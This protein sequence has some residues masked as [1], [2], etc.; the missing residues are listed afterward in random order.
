MSLHELPPLK[1]EVRKSELPGDSGRGVFATEDITKGEMLC[2]YDGD[3]VKNDDPNH[4]ESAYLQ[5][6]NKSGYVVDGYSTPRNPYGV[7][8]LLNDSTC[9]LFDTNQP[10]HRN[11]FQ[12]ICEFFDN[13]EVTSQRKRNVCVTGSGWAFA[14]RDINKGEELYHHYGKGYWI[15]QNLTKCDKCLWRFLFYMS[16]LPQDQC[17]DDIANDIIQFVLCLD[18]RDPKWR[19]FGIDPEYDNET[20]IKQL[21]LLLNIM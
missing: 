12:N 8:Q 11:T 18:S 17:L 15:T 19:N 1:V 10:I 21:K 9:G 13:Y 5:T 14:S 4:L 6:V 16:L 20:K 2:F 7:A 3:L